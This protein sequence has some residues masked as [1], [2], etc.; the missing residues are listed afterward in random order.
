MIK[1]KVEYIKANWKLQTDIE[2][3]R[4][5]GLSHHTVIKYRSDLGLKRVVRGQLTKKQIQILREKYY[6]HDVNYFCDLF[7]VKKYVIYNQLKLIGLGKS[8]GKFYDDISRHFK[9]K[10][11]DTIFDA[12][13]NLGHLKWKQEI[14]KLKKKVH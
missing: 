1:E 13:E 6:D 8:D 2:L 4:N 9:K 10:G 3:A 12:R 11:F 7:K 14:N 5:V